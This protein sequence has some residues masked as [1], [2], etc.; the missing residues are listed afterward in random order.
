MDWSIEGRT[1]I[2]TGASSGLGV[3][4]A[5]VLAGAG[6]NVVLCA[7]REDQLGQVAKEVEANHRS[8]SGETFAIRCDVS[9]PGSVK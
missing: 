3:H 7:R 8:G 4:F 1:A 6:A 2:V 5:Q 9:E